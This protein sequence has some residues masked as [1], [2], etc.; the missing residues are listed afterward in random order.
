VEILQHAGF[1]VIERTVVPDEKEQI[2]DALVR[3]VHTLGIDLI[4]TTGGTGLGARDVT[5]EATLGI[6]DREVPGLAEAM[7]RESFRTT[8]HALISRAV[9]GI[10]RQTLIVNLPGSRKG[11]EEC[12]KVILPAIPHAIEILRGQVVECARTVMSAE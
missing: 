10:R 9:T 4:I 6:I 12:L 5:P 8:P 11:V 3:M 7:R 2:Q 1:E